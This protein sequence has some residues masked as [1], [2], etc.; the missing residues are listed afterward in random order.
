MLR[1]IIILTCLAEI[2]F[3]TYYGTTHD[4]MSL[5]YHN[6]RMFMMIRYLLLI[7]ITV[8]FIQPFRNKILDV[9]S[10]LLLYFILVFEYIVLN[11]YEMQPVIYGGDYSIAENNICDDLRISTMMLS[12]L[13][14]FPSLVILPYIT[15]R[16][17]RGACQ[18]PPA[19]AK[20]D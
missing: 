4:G 19:D 10:S 13:V 11:T 7:I 14:I 8:L 12:I 6:N 18:S 3:M 17:S 15:L 16:L 9:L 2:L 20:T 5:M 1:F